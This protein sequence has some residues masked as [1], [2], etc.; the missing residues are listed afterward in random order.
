MSFL[1]GLLV[2]Q[3]IPQVDRGRLR[4]KE[5]K[6]LTLQHPALIYQGYMAD[7]KADK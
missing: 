3:P 6:A 2:R 7:A 1:F 5:P 4:T